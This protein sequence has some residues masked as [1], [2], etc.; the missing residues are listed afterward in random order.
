VLDIVNET[1]KKGVPD[2]TLAVRKGLD[3]VKRDLLM[4]TLLEMNSDPEGKKVLEKFGAIKFIRTTDA[5]FK[6]VHKLF[7]HLNLDLTT[8][9]YKKDQ[10][11]P[12]SRK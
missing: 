2:N 3:P 5:D 4:K 10:I 11:T 6:P 12:S 9:P 8:Y 7:K 1:P